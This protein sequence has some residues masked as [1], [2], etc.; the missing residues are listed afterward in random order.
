MI[1]IDSWPRAIAHIDCDAFFASVEQAVHPELKGRPVITGAERGIVAAASYEAK[2]AGVKRGVP[3]DEVKRLCP[4]VIMLPSDYETY[5]IFSKRVFEILRRYSPE[6]E[7]YSID[8][9]F[10]DLTGL[11]RVFHSSYEEI[12]RQI[13]ITVKKEL[14]ITVSVGISLSKSLAK[15]CSKL[16]KPSGLVAVKGRE[17]H[18]LL[19]E[20]KLIDVWG[21]GTNTTALLQK[22][23]MKTALDLVKKPKTFAEDLLGKIGIEIWME[24]RG[25]SVY[26]IST[27]AKES[28][29]SISKGKTFVP[30][31]SDPNYVFAQALRNLESACIKARRFDL[32]ARE[33][34]LYLRE[35]DFSGSGASVKLD[36]KTASPLEL[37]V[38]LKDLFR[39]LFIIGKRYRQTVVRL[40]KLQPAGERQFSLFENP[41]NVEK[42]EAVTLAI[43]EV[44]K[45]FGKHSLFLANGL[46]L[47]N[48]TRSQH[49]KIPMLLCGQR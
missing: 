8:E 23:G 26:K 32:S 17:I 19:K 30:A 24:L 18:H 37:T 41:E 4:N 7:E 39:E 25:E 2:V 45:R 36:N 1:R 9:A 46:Y 27:Q 20:T 12:G 22:H 13:M 10:C 31:S 35:A 28:Y 33:L 49:L 21:F 42:I 6:V 48:E 15:L 40:G 34:S 5:S 14:D 44:N 16:K 29:V 11:R 3:L 47:K 38:A 43:D